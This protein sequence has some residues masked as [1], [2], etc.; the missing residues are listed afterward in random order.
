[1]LCAAAAY[2][3]YFVSSSVLSARLATVVS[4]A[5]AIIVY[6]AAIF[7]FGAVG[8]DDIML[9]PKGAKLCGILKK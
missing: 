2:G 4:I 6:V 9:L 5:A 3:A 1:M 8:E 7:L